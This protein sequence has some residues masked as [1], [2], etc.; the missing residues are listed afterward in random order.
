MRR[1][2]QLAARAP[3]T[4]W[5]WVLGEKSGDEKVGR[6]CGSGIGDSWELQGS[7]DRVSW[8]GVYATCGGGLVSEVPTSFHCKPC[9]SE[10]VRLPMTWSRGLKKIGGS[11]GSVVENNVDTCTDSG[12]GIEWLKAANDHQAGLNR[13]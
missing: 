1:W 4:P 13:D 6:P 2:A 3:A 5:R 9:Q 12:H 8:A 7:L 10:F 11:E